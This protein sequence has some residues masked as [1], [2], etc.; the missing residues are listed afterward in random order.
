[1]SSHLSSLAA[2][3]ERFAG[4]AGLYHTHRPQPPAVLVDLLCRAAGAE[5]PGLV[6]DL[7]CGTGLSTRVWAERAERV[8]GIEPSPDMRRE[9]ER[10]T[11]SPNVS[12]RPGFSH[13]T[14]LPDACADVLTC[15][16][17]LH[18]ME[19]E[20]TFQEVARVLR[21]GGVFAAYDCDWP[22]TLPRWEAE[23]AYIEFMARV[24]SMEKERGLAPDVKRWP[25]DG[26]L[27]RM[28]ASNRFRFTKELVVHHL[29]SGNAERLVGL[30][31]SQ[32]AVETLLKA[33]VTEAEMGL[34]RL[35]EVA[36]RTLG[37]EPG[38]WCFSYRARI[39]V[40]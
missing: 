23:A 28:R 34:D 24:T 18:W 17:A 31:L 13:Q 35:R 29:E 38:P 4:F 2:N 37:D 6:V 27:A 30:A 33:G 32:G 10:Q 15:S 9:A 40:V 16:Q 19:P 1:M 20:P 12:F 39:G 21:R 22:P 8:L 25:K 36:A 3:V 5:R 26:H 14:G 7:G 11:A